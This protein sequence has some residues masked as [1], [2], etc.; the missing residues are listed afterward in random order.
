MSTQ[1]ISEGQL[2]RI[3]EAVTAAVRPMFQTF[4]DKIEEL[5]RRQ[6]EGKPCLL[7]EEA[8]NLYSVKLSTLRIMAT[9][10]T[11]KTTKVGKRHYVTP[12]EMDR[13]FKGEVIGK[14]SSR[15]Q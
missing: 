13:V 2:V 12:A 9:K 4:L 7:L 14:H 11:V 5:E 10:G 3:M 6:S 15:R 1:E 8:A